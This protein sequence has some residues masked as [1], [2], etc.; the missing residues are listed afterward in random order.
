MIAMALANE[1]RLLIADEPTTAL[2]VTIQAQI[3]ELIDELAAPARHGHH[4]GHPRPRRHRRARR[5]GRGDVRGPDRG[6]HRRP[7]ALSRSPRHPYTEA[8]FDVAA[9]SAA[10]SRAAELYS[11]P[12]LPPDLTEPPAG[13]RFAPR[14]R[15]RQ[16]TCR[17]QSP[18]S[19][20]RPRSTS[21]RASSRSARC[22]AAR[23]GRWRSPL[24]EADPSSEEMPAARIGG[25]AARRT[26]S[27]VKDFPVTAGAVLRKQ[28]RR[29]VH[30]VSDVSFT[31]RPRRDLR[32]GRR[33]RLRQDHAGPA[34]GRPG[35][36]RTPARSP[37]TAPTWSE[38]RGRECGAGAATSR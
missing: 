25:A 19:A 11:I 8:L 26:Q 31:H 27:L 10:P 24:S 17:E 34:A 15:A 7:P 13:C 33:V 21:T 14:C 38:L 1:P 2:D 30:A 16:E 35:A 23:R 6:E 36:G 5:P 28:D 9:A 37:W 4:P 18:R 29:V 22:R 32:P 3:L 12:G 20:A